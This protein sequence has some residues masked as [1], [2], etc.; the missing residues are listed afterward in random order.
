MM[1]WWSAL[2][3]L[4]DANHDDR[5]SL[6][7]LMTVVDQLHA[8]D[9]AVYATA[10]AMFEAID[11]NGDGRI[12]LEEH[13]QVVAAWKGTDDGIEEVFGQ[14]DLNGDGHLS[15]AEFRELWS[16]F[17]RGDDEAHPGQLG[18]WGRSDPPPRASRQRETVLAVTANDIPLR[19]VGRVAALWRYPVKSMAAERLERADVSWHGLAGDRRWGFVRPGLERSDF[20]WLT[21]RQRPELL[22][23]RPR[24]VEPGR[25]DDSQVVVRTPGGD[26]LDVLDA[27]LADQLDDGARVMKQRRGIFDTFAL[28]LLTS[29][30]GRRPRGACQARARRA[31]LSPEPPRPGHGRRAVCQRM[32]GSAACCGSATR[33]SASTSATSAASSS[34]SIRRRASATRRSSASSLASAILSRRLRLAPC[35]PAA[36]SRGPG[37]ARGRPQRAFSP[38]N[39]A[40]GFALKFS[41]GT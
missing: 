37:A 36:G 1:G 32:R 13:K 29:Q 12:S 30:I 20:P 14:L 5:V 41:I 39:V 25:P 26:E 31:A 6:D 38:K 27:A 2:Q 40:T 11:S 18:R 10:D 8:M 28:S 4:S 15:Q 34:T 3:A 19:E 21:I 24:L 7:E 22:Q 9:D 23:Y 35:G 16:E 33:A 17:W